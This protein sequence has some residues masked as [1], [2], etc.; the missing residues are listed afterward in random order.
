MAFAVVYAV[1]TRPITYTLGVLPSWTEALMRQSEFGDALRYY[2]NVGSM[3]VMDILRVIDRAMILPFV[4]VFSYTGNDAA[5]LA[6]R[7]SPLFVLL[8]PLGYGLGYTQGRKLRD[9]I[10]T[11]IKMGDDRKKRRE[12]KARKQRQRSKSP[13]RLI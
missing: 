6:E 5:L 11:G 3:G 8:A 2:E 12:R 4:N 1:L 9:K 7:L 13:E 10:N